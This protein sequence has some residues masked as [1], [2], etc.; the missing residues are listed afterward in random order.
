MNSERSYARTNCSTNELPCSKS[1]QIDREIQLKHNTVQNS[2]FRNIKLDICQ[3]QLITISTTLSEV[4][5][6]KNFKTQEIQHSATSI[7]T[8][9]R[10]NQM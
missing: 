2:Y 6:K 5:I 7:S 10:R 1:T 9:Q 3:L 4:I 8:A